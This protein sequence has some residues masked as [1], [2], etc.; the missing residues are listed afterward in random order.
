MR[1]L[2]GFVL[3]VATVFLLAGCGGSN[4]V[5]VVSG[6][7]VGQTSSSDVLIAVL[8]S[9][10][11][12]SGSSRLV[13]AYVSDGTA[14][15]EF[16]SGNVSGNFLSLTAQDGAQ[17]SGVFL[18]DHVEGSVALPG[19]QTLDFNLPS[20]TGI[21]GLYDVTIHEDDTV[22]GSFGAL[23]LSG[24]VTATTQGSGNLVVGQI[25]S[26]DFQAIATSD[27]IGDQRWIVLNDGR[28]AGGFKA[29]AGAGF[30]G[31]VP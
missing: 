6:R 21:A 23:Q 3:L 26:T 18:S 1:L 24:L 20:A 5:S 19:A 10:P 31:P 25:G 22:T 14:I 30:V 28:I 13:R 15:N 7:F 9:A 8:A 12:G 16:F 11:T 17:I 29:G 2:N 27:A 4:D